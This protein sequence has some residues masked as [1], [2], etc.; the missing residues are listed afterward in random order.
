MTLH[1]DITR[2]SILKSDWLYFLQWKM[3]KLYAVSKI[4]TRSWLWLTSWTPY[5]QF[6]LKLKKV[7][8]T[9]R[10]FSYDINQIPYNYTVEVANRFKGIDL[11]ECQK[12]YGLRF[13]TLYRRKLSRPSPRRRNAK[14]QIGCLKGLTNGWEKEENQKVKKESEDIPIWMQSSKE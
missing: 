8:K 13:K 7:G 6:R 2:W 4:K 5:S 11:I 9:T 10:A 3:E 12:N 14:S 1:M